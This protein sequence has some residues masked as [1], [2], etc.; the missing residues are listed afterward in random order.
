M[1]LLL[2]LGLLGCTSST[3]DST[4]TGETATETGCQA[5]V[6]APET[7]R[8]EGVVPGS[9]VSATVMVTN[10][11][12]Y[13]SDALVFAAST[14]DL[15]FTVDN[16][17]ETT[18]A[19]TAYATLTVTFTAPDNE[20]HF[21]ALIL[22]S[23]DATDPDHFV[24]LEGFV[25][26]DA[27]GDGFANLGAGGDDCNDN[28]AA[29][30]P[31]ANEI[32]YDGADQDCDEGNDYDQDGDGWPA[33]AYGG[34]DCDD[35]D[36]DTH[37]GAEE[38]QND[39]DDDCDGMVDE[40]FVL[41]GEVLVTE[42]MPTPGGVEDALGEWLEV[43]NVGAGRIDL[44][45]WQLTNSRGVS[46]TVDRHVDVVGGGRVVLG[47]NIDVLTNGNVHVDAEYDAATF[48]L[49][50][51]DSLT[52]RVDG[53]QIAVASWSSATPGVARALD[54]DHLTVADAADSGWWCDATRE[55]SATDLGTPAELN[56]QC[57]TVDEDGDGVS[58]ADGDC[59]DADATVNGDATDA[60][61]GVDND[62]DGATDNPDVADVASAVI[63]G[64][65]ASTYL[66]APAGI[67]TGDVTGDGIDDLV[68][69]SVY[70][71]SYAGTA[72]VID[73]TD[74]VGASGAAS[75]ID[76]AT[77]NGTT[78]SYAGAL[79]PTFSDSTGDGTADVVVGGSPYVYYG[80]YAAC[81][82]AGGASLSGVMD[83]GDAAYTIASDESYGYGTTR[84][85]ADVDVNGD[86]I[87]EVVRANGYATSGSRYYTGAVYVFDVESASGEI[88]AEDALGSLIGAAAAAYLGTSI[89]SGDLD[90][91]GYHD[92]VVGAPG[93]VGAVSGG[94]VAYIVPGDSIGGEDDVDDLATTTIYG[95][96]VNGRLGQG[97]L[98]VADLDA[99]GGLD[100]AIGG[101][102]TN[103]A[104]VFFDVGSVGAEV[105]TSTADT[106]LTGANNFGFSLH[107][108]DFDRDGAIDLAVGAPALNPTFSSSYAW[109]TAPGSGFGSVSI[110]D[111]AVLTAGGSHTATEAFRGLL[112]ATS[113]DLFGAVLGAG[114]FDDDGITDAVV[115][116]PQ[117]GTGAGTVYVVLGN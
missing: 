2:L 15:A 71:S 32:W 78:Y 16:T 63:T 53:R 52:L 90:G 84:I 25:T 117:A 64:G 45:S 81:G 1:R 22:K 110:F 42:V 73:S 4:E 30:H 13:G 23:N 109:Y 85:L 68:V 88:A 114:D 113:A 31:G 70:A 116:A 7:L 39:R 48:S 44:Y 87:G 38:L 5:L 106:A 74:V 37:P 104:Y 18:L 57:T 98:V 115:A 47:S 94:G 111:R 66:G 65:A 59:D 95:S 93:A 54:P 79:P 105:E 50:E 75:A 72:W 20:S 112:G 82:Y 19:P 21:G 99:S 91:D 41:A 9:P 35:V 69:A 43:T 67:G 89:A 28:D 62:C 51:S 55:I 29:V 103:A 49:S 77:L 100:L 33:A 83:D 11:C 96:D 101:S 14:S 27:D 12:D 24:T 107:A 56:D 36:D 108:A 92:L 40:D 3:D 6:A 86:G 76:T 26:T 102:A 17:S 34:N 8:W 61:D 46:F 80:G 58:E 60:W 10:G 97:G